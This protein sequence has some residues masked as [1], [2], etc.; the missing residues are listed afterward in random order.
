MALDTEIYLKK[1]KK[2]VLQSKNIHKQMG[3]AS[4]DFEMDKLSLL[5]KKT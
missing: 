5:S 2:K 1:K 4:W 3:E